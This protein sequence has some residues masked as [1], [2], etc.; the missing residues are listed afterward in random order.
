MNIIQEKLDEHM[1]YIKSCYAEPHRHYHTWQHIEEMLGCI[2]LAAIDKSGHIDSE[3]VRGYWMCKAAI[4]FH[5][6]VYDPKSTTNEEASIEIFMNL[7]GKY[8]SKTDEGLISVAILETK[9]HNPVTSLGKSLCM[10][11]LSIFNKPFPR[12]MEFEDQ[13]R[14]EYAWVPK[15][16][17]LV[18]RRKVLE[19]YH[20][21]SEHIEYMFHTIGKE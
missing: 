3:L 10:L 19:K 1:D 4:Y 16:V 17:Y 7:I 8:I 20:A 2:S 18:E 12:L 6:I 9:N 21:K 5:D 11:D 14:K 15:D 13:I